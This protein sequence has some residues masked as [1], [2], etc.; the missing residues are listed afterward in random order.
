MPDLATGLKVL[1]A[2]YRHTVAEPVTGNTLETITGVDAREIA[3]IVSVAVTWGVPVGSNARG[4]FR[5]RNAQ[6][7]LEYIER[8]KGRLISLGR[9]IAGAKRSTRNELTLFESL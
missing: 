4:Y 8:E 5:F 6:E 7:K 3:E 9:K 2:I 1:S